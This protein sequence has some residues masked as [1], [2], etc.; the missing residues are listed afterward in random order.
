M[1]EK[2]EDREVF[3]RFAKPGEQFDGDWVDAL[4]KSSGLRRTLYA[5]RL[6]CL[7]HNAPSG[8]SWPSS[9]A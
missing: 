1:G 8:P 7:P 2:L 5:R 9:C 6:N 3:K 4:Q